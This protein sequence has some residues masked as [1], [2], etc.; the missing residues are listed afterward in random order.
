LG[1][2]PS[3]AEAYGLEKQFRLGFA[4]GGLHKGAWNTTLDAK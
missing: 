3:I 4:L 1:C 2:D